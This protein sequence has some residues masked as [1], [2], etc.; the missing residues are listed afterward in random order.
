MLPLRFLTFS[1]G[2]YPIYIFSF[3]LAPPP[4]PFRNKISEEK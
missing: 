4:P 3:A 2:T 1:G